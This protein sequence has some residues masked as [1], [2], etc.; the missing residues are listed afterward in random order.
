[1]KLETTSM[2]LTRLQAEAVEALKLLP[3]DNFKVWGKGFG[4]HNVALR[5]LHHRHPFFLIYKLNGGEE[6]W[7]LA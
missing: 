7:R 1:M 6:Q 4:S 2:R 5:A 3:P